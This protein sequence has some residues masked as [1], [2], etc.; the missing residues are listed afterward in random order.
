MTSLRVLLL[1]DNPIDAELML[2]ELRRDGFEPVWRRV[3]SADD[4]AGALS[5]ELDV[6]LSDYSLPHFDALAALRVVEDSQLGLPFIV[7]SGAISE[8]V[9]VDCMKRGAADYILKDRLARLGQAVR[10]AMEAKKARDEQRRAEAAL[11]EYEASYRLLAERVKDVIFRYRLQPVPRLELVTPAVARVTGYSPEELYADPGLAWQILLPEDRPTLEDLRLGIPDKPVTL[12]VRHRNGSLVWLEVS[13]T[14]LC[15]ESGELAGLEG[16]ARDVTERVLSEQALRESEQRYR[17]LIEINPDAVILHDGQHILLLNESGARLLGA[18]SPKQMVGLPMRSVVHPDCWQAF[19]ARSQ[20][21][22]RSGGTLPLMDLR[23]LRQDG[24]TVDVQSTGAALD[25]AGNRVLLG[26]FRDVTEYR[27]ADQALR[28]SEARFRAVFEQAAIGIAVADLRGRFL[29]SNPALQ[30]MLGYSAE[31]LLR[32]TAGTVTH[33]DDRAREDQ[34]ARS[35]ALGLIDRYQVEKRYLTKNGS[36]IWARLTVSL[37]HRTGAEDDLAIGLVEDITEWKRAETALKESQSLLASIYDTVPVG[38]CVTDEAGRFLEVNA[39]FCRILDY[40]KAGVLGRNIGEVVPPGTQERLGTFYARLLGGLDKVPPEVKTRRRNGELVDLAVASALLVRGDGQPLAITTIQDITERKKAEETRG[41][42]AA[43]VESTQDAIIGE[44]LDGAITSW[45]PAAERLYGYSADEAIGQSVLLIVPPDRTGEAQSISK[46]VRQ[47]E[48]VPAYDTVGRRNDSSLVHVSLCISPIRDQCGRII[49]ASRIAHD[50]TDRLRTES[51]LRESEERYRNLVLTAHDGILV[52]VDGKYV[53]ANP[54]ALKILGVSRLEDLVGRPYSDF[55]P[56]DYLEMARARNARLAAGAES[57]PIAE[58]KRV[59]SDGTMVDVEVR[60]TALVYEDKPAVQVIMRD[61]SERTQAAARLNEANERLSATLRAIPDLLFEVD[62]TGHIHSYH[63]SMD[64]PLLTPPSKF[65]GRTVA[66]VLPVEAAEVIMAA[67]DEAAQQG[68]HRGATFSLDLPDGQRWFELSV[69][70]KEEAGAPVSQFVITVR[71]ITERK[72]S[73]TALRESEERFQAVFDN[74]PNGIVLTDFEGRI[75][76]ANPA[77]ER[78]MGYNSQELCRLS[79]IDRVFAD[80]LPLTLEQVHQLATAEREC[81][82]IERRNVRQDGQLVWVSVISS[83]IRDSQGRPRYVL[84]LVEDITRRKEMEEQIQRAQRLEIAGRVAAQVAHDFNNL[85]VPVAG[86]PELIKMRLPQGDPA[87]AMCD[88][89]LEAARSMAAINEN[90]LALGRRGHIQRQATDMNAVVEQA[91]A[92]MPSAPATLAVRLD[93]APGLPPVDGAQAQLLRVVANLVA[94]ARDATEDIG[95]ISIETVAC[96][97]DGRRL[98]RYARIEVGEYVKLT[99]SDTGSGIADAIRDKV[100]DA[101]FTT[102]RTDAKRGS[103]LGL[104]VVQ[105][106]VDDHKG[107]ID[108]ET[109]PGRGTTFYVYL[110]TGRKR[111]ASDSTVGQIGGTESLLVVD[112]ERF[113]RLVAEQMLQ[114]LGYQVK[115]VTSGEEAVAYLREHRADLVLLDM[116]MPGGM[117]GVETYERIVKMKPGQKAIIVSGFAETDRV[118][119][120]QRLGAGAFCQKPLTLDQLAQAVRAELG[121]GR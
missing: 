84:S 61:I 49:G 66:E 47:G 96:H 28:Q 89:V 68:S 94:N 42:L 13:A 33:P 54:A 76:Q 16:I 111:V 106:I 55:V 80:D 75:V 60:A 39:A 26:V 35:L 40:P 31:D 7:V 9:A 57:V 120:A 1:E 18:A 81:T 5:P 24:S 53:F 30:R 25:V 112:D 45:N 110:P 72:L 109:V 103:G 15:D 11:R 65:L 74:A 8:E 70:S 88:V 58:Q 3:E 36:Q 87:A 50:I 43:I 63:G 97:L 20:Q 41:L 71:D 104:T 4:F 27:R 117:D 83:T 22:L 32:M 10:H 34:L 73:E 119:E 51:A 21:L 91:V 98:G 79:V 93:L 86:L 38:I 114:V 64:A 108:L 99:V 19:V 85:L 12:R 105:S 107:Y 29:D 118:R 2:R 67:I 46:R 23:Y 17:A 102:K 14:A 121:R 69:A 48:H 52:H 113:Q 101:F 78:I 37:V 44:T 90:M 115:T 62:R 6:V 56:A 59:R 116:V 100:F 92:N 95:V 82:Y 77:Q